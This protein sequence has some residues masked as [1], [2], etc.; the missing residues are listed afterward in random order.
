[1]KLSPLAKILRIFWYAVPIC[2]AAFMMPENSAPVST[3][4]IHDSSGPE[5]HTFPRDVA[6]AIV[7]E[8][9]D[10]MPY[11]QT[12]QRLRDEMGINVPI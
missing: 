11:L 5:P 6:Q 12:Q 10:P 7:E 9:R 4:D 8:G 3:G 2:L 1:M